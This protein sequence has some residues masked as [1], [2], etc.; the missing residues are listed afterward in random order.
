METGTRKE[1]RE[2]LDL[3]SLL[4]SQ[5]VFNKLSFTFI[6]VFLTCNPSLQT[7]P[8]DEDFLVMKTKKIY[9]NISMLHVLER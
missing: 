5:K 2:D 9:Q 7:V 8:S 4:A 3:A 1:T 6:S